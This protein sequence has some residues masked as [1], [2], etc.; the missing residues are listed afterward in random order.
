MH[1]K[2]VRTTSGS[3][4]HENF[5]P[6]R[7][8]A[9]LA[10]LTKA[11]AVL[12]GK[13]NL[14]EFAFGVTSVNPHYGAVVNPW[15]SEGARISGGSSGGSAAALAAGIGLGSLG[16][17]TAGSIRIPAALCGIVGLKPTYGA[18]SRD[19]VTPLSWSL[20]HVGPMGKTVS[21]VSILFDVLAGTKTHATLRRDPRG[22]ALGVHERYFF[23]D[24]A[25]E[26]HEAVEAAIEALEGLGLTRV[27]MDVPEIAVQSACR[28]AIAFSEAAAFHADDVRARPYDYGADTLE[29]LRTGLLLSATDYVIA[30][31]AR[32]SLVRAFYR[33]FDGV[34]VLVTPAT[35]AACSRVG[36]ATLD[37]GEDVRAGLLR[38]TSPFNTVGFPAVSVPCGF[39]TDGRPIG[40]QL[41]AKPGEE[42]VLLRVAH[43]YERSQSFRLRRPVI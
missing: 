21:D 26:V 1:S 10:A 43:A 31:R 8:A 18:V 40:L 16:S 22:L 3:K 11:G 34:D 2:D 41:V 9:C 35:V 29:L 27:P 33:A 36:A 30:R 17:D 37:N 14:H 20:D 39:T 28:N 32:V 25:P 4:I 42:A 24:V 5:V 38:M 23:D 6:E 13:T 7:D 15:S 12:V 19:G